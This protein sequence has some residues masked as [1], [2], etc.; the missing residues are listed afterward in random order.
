MHMSTHAA[1][2]AAMAVQAG[3]RVSL[4]PPMA[5]AAP[6]FTNLANGLGTADTS[7][8]TT[9]SVTLTANRL[10][11]LTIISAFNNGNT[12]TCAG[13]DLVATV[14]HSSLARM[15]I[16]RRMVGS[17]LTQTHTYSF[18]GQ[19]QYFNRWSIDQSSA[20]VNTG[21][22]NGSNAIVQAVGNGAVEVPPVT[23]GQYVSVTLAAFS[24]VNNSTFAA[25]GGSVASATPSVGSGF[26]ELA[27]IGVGTGDYAMIVEYK[28]ANDTV[29]DATWTNPYDIWVGV[30]AEIRAQ[31]A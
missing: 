28:A 22:T 13:W 1:V 12:P 21:G 2:V 29:A 26:T 20:D 5:G 18:G 15:T 10:A 31:G 19:N 17:D 8:T 25:F 6:T 16:L 27:R 11:L 24:N 14:Q 7:Q 3:Q 23:N 30:A 9:T 4:L